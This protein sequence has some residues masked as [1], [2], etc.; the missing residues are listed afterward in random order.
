MVL[1]KMINKKV[2]HIHT[3]ENLCQLL[4]K[5]KGKI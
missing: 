4:V 1:T 2:M 3:K 5:N